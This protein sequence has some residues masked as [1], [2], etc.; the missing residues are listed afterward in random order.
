M[1]SPDGRI[2][3]SV[4][5]YGEGGPKD[6]PGNRAYVSEEAALERELE[7]AGKWIVDSEVESDGESDYIAETFQPG[8]RSAG[9]DRYAVILGS[10]NTEIDTGF[11]F[12]K[13]DDGWNILYDGVVWAAAQDWDDANNAMNHIK[14]HTIDIL[15]KGPNA[16]KEFTAQYT[17][18]DKCASKELFDNGKATGAVVQ[19]AAGGFLCYYKGNCSEEI[20]PTMEA[21]Q[22]E[23]KLRYTED[24]FKLLMEQ[25]FNGTDEDEE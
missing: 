19:P 16:L 22:A 20:F 17:W 18:K 14:S 9:R 10:G 4:V 21:A 24:K 7:L 3:S 25:T 11:I 23:T 2:V 1:L 8:L 13:S 15:S 6:I 12:E 5:W